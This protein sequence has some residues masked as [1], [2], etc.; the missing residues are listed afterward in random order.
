M[1]KKAKHNIIPY[2]KLDFSHVTFSELS[3]NDRVPSQKLAYFRH[4]HPKKG[5]NQFD[6]QSPEILLDNYGIP[7]KEG[8]YYQTIKQQAFLKIPLAIDNSPETDEDRIKNGKKYLKELNGET[9]DERKT[10]AKKLLAFRDALITF[11]KWIVENKIKI[12]GSAKQ[13]KKYEYTPIVRSPQKRDVDSDDEDSDEDEKVEPFRPQYAK[14]KIPLDYTTEVPETEVFRKNLDGSDA[15]VADGKY[16][17]VTDSITSL[18]ELRNRIGFMRKGKFVLHVCKLW[19]SK[20]AANGQDT[21]KFGVTLKLRRIEVQQRP[22]R[23][24]SEDSGD[25]ENPFIDSDD[26]DEDETNNVKEMIANN[27]DSDED[28]SESDS[29]E[30][31]E[32]EVVKKSKGKKAKTKN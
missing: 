7:G 18:D 9:E 10:R 19:A 24:E 11:D 12:F 13:A 27:E 26:E 21:R 8:P 1:S 5:E 6:I 16:S 22:M 14:A 32:E 23:E 28:S 31:E 15:F 20:Q 4:K 29:D 2:T 3:D 17:N 30:E 25:K